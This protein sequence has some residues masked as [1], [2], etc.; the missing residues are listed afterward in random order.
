MLPP[1]FS[2]IRQM[3]AF[4]ALLAVI[5]ALPAL[6]A[7]TGW[8]HLDDVY[9]AIPWNYGEFPWTQQKIFGETGDVDIVFIGSSHIWSDVDTP[10]VQKALSQHLGRRATVFTI[11][12]PW[13]GFD[14]SYTVA[15]DLLN[16]RRVHMLVMDDEDEDPR[17]APHLHAARWFRLGSDPGELAGLP[18]VDKA[19]L[20]GSAVLGMPR[21]LLSLVR[22]DIL[23]NP[24]SADPAFWR[25][26][27]RVQNFA[28]HLGAFS[29]RIGYDYSPDFVE[30][31]PPVA[32]T[33][34]DTLIYSRENRDAFSFGG[35]PSGPYQLHFIRK[36][37]Q[38][39]LEK[40]T[41]LVVLKTPSVDEREETSV[42]A[43]VLWPEALGAPVDIVGI[44]PAKLFGAMPSDDVRKLF[45]EKKHLNQNGQKFFT[46]LITPAL[47]NLYADSS[48][49][50]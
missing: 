4:A 14:V 47:I 7:Q 17:D 50:K 16:H 15:R 38:L 31:H 1:A 41:R 20:Y 13:A 23:E 19:S 49:P 36:I 30:F 27:Y 2:S 11:G 35:P 9:P 34:A 18:W 21:Q 8:Q 48:T 3:A 5:M 43:R 29:A 10:Y 45:Y 37:A 26:T 25:T 12:W 46:P 33:A 44:P 32:A 39:C 22:P 42:S 40:R 28:E 6:V 24:A